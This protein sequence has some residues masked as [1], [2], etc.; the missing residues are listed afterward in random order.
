MIRNI[1]IGIV[2]VS[3]AYIAFLRYEVN[4]SQ[5]EI[6]KLEVE[7]VVKED[8]KKVEVFNTKQKTTFEL[9]KGETYEEIPSTIG[10]HTLDLS[11]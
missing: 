10:I 2:L 1:L 7:V 11:K 9:K 6:D 5:Q 3:L 4:S 8:E